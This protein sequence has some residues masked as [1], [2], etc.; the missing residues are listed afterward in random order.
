MTSSSRHMVYLFLQNCVSFHPVNLEKHSLTPYRNRVI[1]PIQSHKKFKKVGWR[2]SIARD[3]NR[4]QHILLC[5]WIVWGMVMFRTWRLVTEKSF[6]FFCSCHLND[7]PNAGE[8]F[9][10]TGNLCWRGIPRHRMVIG[11]LGTFCPS[12]L[13]NQAQA[14]SS[15]QVVFHA[16]LVT[17]M[18]LKLWESDR[19]SDLPWCSL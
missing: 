19:H 18:N 16:L 12:A 2:E 1:F 4:A 14:F 3:P 10:F 6:R 8:S 17:K 7:G 13:V 15:A 5:L 11:W 9:L